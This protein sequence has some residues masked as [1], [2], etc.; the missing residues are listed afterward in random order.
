MKKMS[1]E[2]LATNRNIDF[3]TSPKVEFSRH[4]N[5]RFI[6]LKKVAFSVGQEV[7]NDFKV[8]FDNLNHR[9]FDIIK[10]HFQLV[11]RPNIS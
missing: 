4:L 2:C 6:D 5:H 1:S 8:T 9:F 7:K 10:L 3:S 11:Q